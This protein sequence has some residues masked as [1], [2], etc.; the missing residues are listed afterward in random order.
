[1]YLVKLGQF[2]V[3]K[4]NLFLYF[5]GKLPELW[6]ADRAACTESRGNDGNRANVR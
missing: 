2:Q 4:E 3:S 1:M 5:K 6:P